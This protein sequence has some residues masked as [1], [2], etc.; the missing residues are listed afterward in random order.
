MWL[1]YTEFH[2]NIGGHQRPVG[3]EGI[4]PASSK[5]NITAFTPMI[6]IVAIGKCTGRRELSLKD[7]GLLFL[8]NNVGTANDRS[9]VGYFIIYKKNHIYT[10][11]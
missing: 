6:N 4:P 8:R 9:M 1:C 5:R 10:D 11:Y 2:D 7:H 3:D